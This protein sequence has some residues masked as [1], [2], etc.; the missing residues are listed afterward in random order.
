MATTEQQHQR[1]D[2]QQAQQ[3]LS[4]A[5][6][7]QQRMELVQQQLGFVVDMLADKKQAHTAVKALQD[8]SPGDEVLLPIGGGTFLNATLADTTKVIK[9]IGGDYATE[10]SLVD[11]LA[12]LD[13]EVK[14]LDAD[15]NV[16]RS[17]LQ[18]LE[19][20]YRQ[21]EAVLRQMQGQRA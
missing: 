19:S 15:A 8:A 6:M 3:L 18:Q 14:A 12:E 1:V 5:E 21:I 11:A 9:G 2:P 10:R 17:S 13:E 16:M 4:Q 7:I 20:N